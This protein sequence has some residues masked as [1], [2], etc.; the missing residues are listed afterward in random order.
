MTSS[1]PVLHRRIAIVGAGI[2]GAVAAAEL[3]RL[4]IRKANDS[5]SSR[6][7]LHEQ[8]EIVVFDQGRRGP[9]GRAS[10]R[11]VLIS[12]GEVL[13]D[14]AEDIEKYATDHS[15]NDHGQTYQFDHGC[16]FFR[17]DSQLM[18]ESLLKQWL[19]KEWVEP[20]SARLGCLSPM[21]SADMKKT[22]DFFIICN[23]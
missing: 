22:V 7:T 6:D 5:S 13:A 4:W 18:R 14:D 19:S 2:T 9:G 15:N 12:T 16:Q 10:H 17:A 3:A 8:M 1:C 21:T 20:W 23:T 11:S